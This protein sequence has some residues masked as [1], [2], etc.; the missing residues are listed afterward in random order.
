MRSQGISTERHFSTSA[1]AEGTVGMF[2]AVGDALDLAYE[3]AYVT[4]LKE[5]T[6]M[7]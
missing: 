1:S 4:Q 6:L 2:E 5:Q 7:G 3:R